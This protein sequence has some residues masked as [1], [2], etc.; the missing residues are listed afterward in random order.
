M[1]GQSHPRQ[2]WFAPSA[3]FSPSSFIPH[4]FALITGTWWPFVHIRQ[5][6]DLPR[7]LPGA[8]NP[9]CCH[10]FRRPFG[11]SRGDRPHTLPQLHAEKLAEIFSG[12][13]INVERTMGSE[14]PGTMTRLLDDIRRGEAG[15]A[16]QLAQLL[17]AELYQ[18]AQGALRRERAGHT[19]STTD[20]VHEVFLRLMKDDI[21]DKAQNR[22]Y[23]FGAV[24]RALRQVLVDHAR[25]RAA[26]RRG[27]DWKRTPL[28]EALEQYERER[29][30]LFALNEAL[31][32]LGTLHPRQRQ[33][34]DEYH[35]G[36]YTFWE[37]A[38][39]LGVS[40]ATVCTDWQRARLWL[41]A[42][43]GPES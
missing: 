38:E 32:K 42:Q 35:F 12:F 28:D 15:A 19:L 8:Y 43:L 6:G 2:S 22:A 34:V 14:S 37:I 9:L 17:G 33:I 16:D 25:K 29:I 26:A 13:F 31:E 23:L 27:G 39:H 41:A 11:A 5:S 18:L 7:K 20:L 1:K 30:D 24:S 36:G 21:W 10:D 3:F 4:P 40:E